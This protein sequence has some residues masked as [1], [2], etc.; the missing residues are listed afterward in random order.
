MIVTS[1]VRNRVATWVEDL[2]VDLPHDAVGFCTAVARSRGRELRLIAVDTVGRGLPSGLFYEQ[3]HV[4]TIIYDSTTTD[5]HQSAIILHELWHLVAGHNAAP[6]LSSQA[7]EA[8]PPAASAGKVTR[9]SARDGEYTAAEEAEAEY[10]ARYV[11]GLLTS[12]RVDSGAGSRL[13]QTFM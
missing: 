1:A 2:D 11:L 3:D 6:A 4:D 13:E 10:F 7:E 8:A 5:Y 12:E 9:W